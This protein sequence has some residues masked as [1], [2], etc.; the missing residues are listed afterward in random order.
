MIWTMPSTTLSVS[1]LNST[2]TSNPLV[3]RIYL[4]IRHDDAREGIYGVLRGSIHRVRGR[5]FRELRAVGGSRK[6]TPGIRR[7]HHDASTLTHRGKRWHLTLSS[8]HGGSSPGKTGVPS[9]VGSATRSAGTR[10]GTSCTGRTAT[11]PWPS[12]VPDRAKFA[13]EDLLAERRRRG[14]RAAGT[15]VSYCGRYEFRGDTVIHRVELSLFPK[16]GRRCAGTPRRSQGQQVDLEHATDIARGRA[17]D[18]PPD[19]GGRRNVRAVGSL[20]TECVEG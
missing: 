6:F 2:L 16:L 17:T 20:F 19:L 4:L 7:W 18:R 9:M 10:W 15:Y 13:T 12:C 8:A 5:A 14:R 3:S 1:I 11:C